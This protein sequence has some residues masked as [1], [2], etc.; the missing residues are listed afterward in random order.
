[1]KD[2]RVPGASEGIDLFRAILVGLTRLFR[3]GAVGDDLDAMLAPPDIPAQRFPGVERE[4]VFTR[5]SQM[6]SR[7]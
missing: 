5:I 6:I 1:M 3:H 2:G 7:V 4:D